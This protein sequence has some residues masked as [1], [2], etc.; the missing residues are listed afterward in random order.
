MSG[1]DWLSFLTM[2]RRSRLVVLLLALLLIS[3]GGAAAPSTAPPTSS[4]G[5]QLIPVLVSSETAVGENRL[6]F[7]IIDGAN[8]PLSAADVAVDLSFQPPQPAPS[9]C[10][11]QEATGV[12]IEADDG[13][14]L[15]RAPVTFDCPGDWTADITAHLADGDRSSRVTFTVRDVWSTPAI[16]E[17][18][19]GTDNPTADS[20]DAIAQIST[21][22][23]PDPD[24]YQSTPADAEAA[25]EPFVVVFAT[26]A[27]CRTAA[28]GPTLDLVK[29]AAADFKDRI[30]FI[31]VEPYQLEER[32]GFLQPLLSESG[33]LQ[34]VAAVDE[35]GLLSEPYVFAVDGEG[36][37]VAKFEGI[38]S[39]EELLEAFDAIAGG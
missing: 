21:D 8:R 26:P 7:N 2:S 18:V 13:R 11:A 30:A 16:G 5:A 6:L 37:L 34:T 32:D 12:F 25:H 28:C 27:F 9:G 19:P 24:F 29:D 39:Q 14:G 4:P 20:A 17:L 23:D 31:H 36:R 38:A 22:D 33:E 35:W 1:H 10:Q 3:C 15:Y